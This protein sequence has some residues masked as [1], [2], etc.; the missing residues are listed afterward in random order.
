MTSEEWKETVSLGAGSDHQ[1]G[2]P[3]QLGFGLSESLHRV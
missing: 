2:S 1:P 3:V